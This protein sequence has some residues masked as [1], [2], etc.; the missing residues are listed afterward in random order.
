MLNME[1]E[2]EYNDFIALGRKCYPKQDDKGITN[3]NSV[4][5]DNVYPKKIDILDNYGVTKCELFAL[6]MMEGFFSECIQRP[7][8][9]GLKPNSFI[10][11]CIYYFDS[12]LSKTPKTSSVVL[13]RQDHFNS[14][15][16][17]K[18]L[19]NKRKHYICASF[20]T[21][22]TDDYD[23]SRSVKLV[24]RPKLGCKTKAH[25]IY[26]IMNHGEDIK[27]AIPENQVNFERNT[28]IEITGID[29][30]PNIPVVYLNEI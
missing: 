25:D 27:E 9:F 2:K 18:D 30:K 6:I 16:Y 10:K 3:F 4:V 19:K 7:L 21:A 1:Q 13:Y 22:S 20:L 15:E 29:E 23:N 17:Y 8:V 24:I 5:L 26:R 14:V 11:R 28:E 12:L